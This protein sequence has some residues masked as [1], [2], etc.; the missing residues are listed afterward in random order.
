MSIKKI[1][2][3]I[4]VFVLSSN[5]QTYMPPSAVSYKDSKQWPIKRFEGFL[6]E[7][8]DTSAVFSMYFDSSITIMSPTERNEV[9]FARKKDR[10]YFY[11]GHKLVGSSYGYKLEE[12]LSAVPN[13]PS[14]SSSLQ[15][16]ESARFNIVFVGVAVVAVFLFNEIIS[17]LADIANL[18]TY[19]E[20]REVES[21]SNLPYGAALAAGGVALLFFLQK[22]FSS[23][24]RM[25]DIRK[26]INRLREQRYDYI[27][28]SRGSIAPYIEFM[29]QAANQ[30]E[31]TSFS[32]SCLGFF[33][34]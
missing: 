12:V 18:A 22:Y 15:L 13:Y 9:T 4:L 11:E 25:K 6:N 34:K 23:T 3:M 19:Y 1:F 7:V 28:I 5:A 16:S 14:N 33:I 24:G 10:I 27:A 21:G 26:S 30:I 29:Q 17:P 31:S 2:V 8:K 20:V 32:T